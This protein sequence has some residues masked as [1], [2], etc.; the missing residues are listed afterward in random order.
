[1]LTAF[2]RAVKTPYEIACMALATAAGVRAHQVAEVGFRSGASEYEI[3]LAYLR[4]SNQ[5][6]EET[7]YAFRVSFEYDGDLKPLADFVED[8]PDAEVLSLGHSL[9][10]I[11][12]L[13][14][15]D[16]VCKQYEL[17]DFN[18][19]HF[20]WAAATTHGAPRGTPR[21]TLRTKRGRPSRRRR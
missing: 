5:V 6:E 19:T 9:E 2:A 4:A 14:D 18:G 10:I 21:S 8:I 7:P 1:M 15:A 20:E 3:H 16:S 11:K 17:D 12:D 13:G